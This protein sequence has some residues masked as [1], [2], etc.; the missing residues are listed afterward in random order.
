[1][2][3][4]LALRYRLHAR[5]LMVLSNAAFLAEPPE[6]PAHP[7]ASGAAPVRIGFLSNITFE[8][9][10]VEF[11]DVLARLISLQVSYH[12]YL[13]GPVAAEAKEVFE[14]MLTSAPNAE[15]LGPVYG[16]AKNRFYGQIDV[17]LFPTKYANEADPLVI[18]EALCSGVYV[19]AC[20]RGA[21]PDVLCNGAGLA[22]PM[23]QFVDQATEC[24]RVMSLDREKLL[25]GQHLA[26]EHARRL[27]KTGSLALENVLESIC[28]GARVGPADVLHG[29]TLT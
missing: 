28:V 14:R 20:S 12:A 29:S 6:A 15:H 7:G 1:M 5:S 11:F 8:K 21:I 18:H 19:I 3:Q 10:F 25:Q 2:G 23:E 9:G 26:L 4:R 27:R 13:A 24:I 16:D 22:F 17:L